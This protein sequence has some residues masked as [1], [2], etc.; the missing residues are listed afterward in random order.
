MLVAN[1]EAFTVG[2]DIL[3]GSDQYSARLSA[4]QQLLAHELTHVVQRQRTRNSG[5]LGLAD[6]PPRSEGIPS[7][8]VAAPHESCS[9]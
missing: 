2:G 4:G 6:D 1:A 8:F 9:I 3:L 5:L 7:E